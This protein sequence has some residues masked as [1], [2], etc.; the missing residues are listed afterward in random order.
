MSARPA[1]PRTLGQ[2][3]PGTASGVE[4]GRVAARTETG[5]RH[6]RSAQFGGPR[7]GASIIG[8]KPGSVSGSARAMCAVR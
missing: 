4:D 1:R 2:T 3:R 8:D 5:G 6:G 7:E